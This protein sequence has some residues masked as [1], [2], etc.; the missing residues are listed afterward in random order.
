[1]SHKVHPKIYRIKNIEDWESRGYYKKNFPLYLEEDFKIR[2]FLTS[3]LEKMGIEK[4]QIERFTEKINVVIFSA[5]PGLIIGRGGEGVE[6]IQ[7][8]IKKI[9]EKNS[10]AGKKAVSI[11]IREIRNPWLSASLSGQWVAQQL[12]RR[13]P[14][15]RVLKQAL[16]KIMTNKEI[17]GARIEVSGRLDGVEIARRE[18]VKKGK[19]PR[20]TI[21]S[22]ID[23]SKNIAKCSYGVIGIKTW[24]YKGE[25][26]N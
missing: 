6:K 2:S 23:Y 14:H 5:R 11:E 9:I 10:K 18:W 13:V 17:Q 25:K 4:I 22:D 24:I 19:L 1:M 15:K 3:K 7:K 21:R 8:E 26:F 12:E 16:D 20:Q